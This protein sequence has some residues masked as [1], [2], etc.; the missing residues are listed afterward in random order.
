MSRYLVFSSL[1]S[2]LGLSCDIFH[3]IHTYTSSI[4]FRTERWWSCKWRG[5]N[6]KMQLM[7]DPKKDGLNQWML[8]KRVSSSKH[9]LVLNSRQASVLCI[10]VYIL[11]VLNFH[12]NKPDNLRVMNFIR[13]L[14]YSVH[15]QNR[16]QKLYCL[17][18]LNIEWL[19][20]D[21]KSYVLLFLSFPKSLG[22]LFLVVWRLSYRHLKCE[23]WICPNLDS[24]A[25]LVPFH[26][27]TH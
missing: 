10:T 21:Y 27:N 15:C 26:L 7:N 5:A 2:I 9:Y 11:L 20:G 17:I 23:V 18:Y 4:S 12:D 16:F 8:A 3:H 19:L 25:F 22:S 24:K 6:P 14:L 13:W 1:P